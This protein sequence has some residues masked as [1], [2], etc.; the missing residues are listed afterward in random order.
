MDSQAKTL[1]ILSK[2]QMLIPV[3]DSGLFYAFQICG[4]FQSDSPKSGVLGA[5]REFVCLEGLPEFSVLST[6]DSS[7]RL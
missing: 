4:N 1:G 7:K 3:H 5:H 6:L 2:A